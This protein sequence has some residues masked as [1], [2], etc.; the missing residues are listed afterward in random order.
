[1]ASRS[2]GEPLR[3]AVRGGAPIARVSV[4]IP[5]FNQ[6]RFL[7][8]TIRSVVDQDY[9]DVEAIVVDGGSTDGSA[10]IVRRYADRL[11]W[12]V[13]EPDEGQATAINKGL[14]R[15]T[16]DYLT[17]LSSDDTY[18]PGALSKLVA[19]IES[20]PETVL[21]YGDAIYTDE[22]SERDGLLTIGPPDWAE[23]VRQC[24]CFVVQPASLFTRRAWELAGPLRE[25]W[26]FFDL[27]LFLAMS[28]HG[29]A[30]QIREPLA[31]YRLHESTKSVGEPLKKAWGYIEFGDEVLQE[32]VLPPELARWARRGRSQAYLRGGEYLY[33]SYELPAA[34]RYL[35]RGHLLDPAN[36]TA[37]SLSIL[38]KSLLPRPAVERLR[39]RRHRRRDGAPR[40]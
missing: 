30:V 3:G 13:S 20:E 39:A 15:A 11:A 34:R 18:L 32:G 40:D 21:A 4:V 38:G 33:W 28:R 9:P 36:T 37:R 23:M 26:W 19:A 24:E 16:G 14:R 8:E 12:W 2:A 7:E 31:T 10:E 17:W 29:P 1:M 5:S 22:N 27:E 6:A 35:L 25:R